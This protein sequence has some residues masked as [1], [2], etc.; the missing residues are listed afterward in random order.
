MNLYHFHSN[1]NLFQ[2]SK[3]D[4][5]KIIKNEKLTTYKSSYNS[6]N[7]T[8]LSIEMTSGH[9]LPYI[10]E[11][12]FY[13]ENDKIATYLNNYTLF[14]KFSGGDDTDKSMPP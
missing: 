5:P 3:L 13:D 2:D 9:P 12:T 4:F 7:I 11:V 1:K 10:I 14:V 6:K 8:K